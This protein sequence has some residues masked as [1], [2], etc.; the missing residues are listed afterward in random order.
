MIVFIGRAIPDA[1]GLL[2]LGLVVRGKVNGSDLS[3]GRCLGKLVGRLVCRLAIRAGLLA[4]R[5]LSE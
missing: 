1:R 3:L 2:A 4:E 5:D